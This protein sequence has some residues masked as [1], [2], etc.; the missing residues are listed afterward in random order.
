MPIEALDLG[1]HNWGSGIRISDGLPEDAEAD[2]V[3]LEQAQSA[4]GL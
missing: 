4:L 3:L 2:E 1:L